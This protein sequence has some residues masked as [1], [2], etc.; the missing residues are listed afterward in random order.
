V[1]RLQ[2][3]P[4][5]ATCS[6]PAHSCSRACQ[7]SLL[8]HACVSALSRNALSSVLV[9]VLSCFFSHVV[10]CTQPCCCIA[11]AHNTADH[12]ACGAQRHQSAAAGTNRTRVRARLTARLCQ[13]RYALLQLPAAVA[14][15][16]CSSVVAQCCIV[17]Q[18]TPAAS[19]CATCIAAGCG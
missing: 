9:F 5:A 19:T 4:C 2:R 18:R 16:A 8:R 17:R 1:I 10:S 6:W 13:L 15:A 7:L 11:G 14:A 12:Q 3:A